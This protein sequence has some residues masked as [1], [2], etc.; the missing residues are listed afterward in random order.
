[1]FFISPIRHFLWLQNFSSS[2]PKTIDEETLFNPGDKNQALAKSRVIILRTVP[3]VPIVSSS[4]HVV[5]ATS[6][7]GLHVIIGLG[8]FFAFALL[9]KSNGQDVE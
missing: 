9:N 5:K 3:L 8:T 2:L 7:I 4:V 6:T 1:M